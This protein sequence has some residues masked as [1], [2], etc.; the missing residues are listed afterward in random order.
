VIVRGGSGPSVRYYACL[1]GGSRRDRSA[2]SVEASLANGQRPEFG[3]LGR[4]EKV[5][6]RHHIEL[7]DEAFDDLAGMSPA[8]AD[9]VAA[10]LER[11]LGAPGREHL[12]GVVV[13][14]GV[15]PEDWRTYEIA[16]Y[17]VIFRFMTA[18]ERR[19]KGVRVSAHIV[20]AIPHQDRLDEVM[21]RLY[22][23]AAPDDSGWD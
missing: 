20:A 5:A 12:Y 2:F 1:P 3:L 23:E 17:T 16:P 9:H 10:Q 14:D 21:R 22:E 4:V 8:D 13:I 15:P 18:T 7:A 19:D 6:V 11:A